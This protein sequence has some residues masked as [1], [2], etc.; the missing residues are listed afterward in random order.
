MASEPRER[1]LYD[2]FGPSLA[3]RRSGL[4]LFR[5]TFFW[6]FSHFYEPQH[7]KTRRPCLESLP[8]ESGLRSGFSIFGDIISIRLP[9]FFGGFALD[10]HIRGGR[11]RHVK[12]L[13]MLPARFLFG[14]RSL[15]CARFYELFIDFFFF[16]A[17]LRPG[18]FGHLFLPSTLRNKVQ[19]ILSCWL[20]RFAPGF[21]PSLS[22]PKPWVYPSPLLRKRLY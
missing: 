11:A 16:V 5:C 17:H 22:S 12:A 20:G 21:F 8:C 3:P 9:S 4:R 13:C 1:L 15:P 18:S 14:V 6:R 7:I 19:R 2:F 10:F